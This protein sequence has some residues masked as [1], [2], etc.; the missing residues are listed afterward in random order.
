MSGAEKKAPFEGNVMA[1][2]PNL[3]KLKCSMTFCSSGAAAKTFIQIAPMH[4]ASLM[5]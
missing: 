1:T 4:A 2:F 3:V 5:S